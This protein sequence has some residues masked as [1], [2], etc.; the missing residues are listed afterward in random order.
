MKCAI[1]FNPKTSAA[2]IA[3]YQLKSIYFEGFPF[4]LG[5][6]LTGSRR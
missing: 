1:T 2:R 6:F 4:K 3:G 5:Q